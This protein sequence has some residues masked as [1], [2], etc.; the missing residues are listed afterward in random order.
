M[1][2]LKNSLLAFGGQSLLIGAIALITPHLTLGQG[3][4]QGGDTVGPTRAVKVV[5]TPAEPVPVTGAITGSVSIT[6][7]PSVTV[8]NT[9]WVN[10]ANSPMV[11]LDPDANA[12]TVAPRETTLLLDTGLITSPD[13]TTIN[14]FPPINIRGYSKIRVGVSSRSSGRV[15]INVRSAVQRVDEQ[16][17]QDYSF[18]L[19]GFRVDDFGDDTG[20]YDVPGTTLIIDV[21]T[22]GERTYRLFVFAN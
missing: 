8:A 15:A 3:Q 12:V 1:Y 7:T 13:G 11:R 5:N 6:N 21:V 19:A 10:V 9:P 20:V 4:G 2:K 17:I 22:T 18:P 16:A 14:R